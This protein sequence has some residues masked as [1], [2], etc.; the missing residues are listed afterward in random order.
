MKTMS[1]FLIYPSTL[2]IETISTSDNI[3]KKKGLSVKAT[4]AW[5]V[6]VI[7]TLFWLGDP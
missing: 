2:S 3:N 4:N 7:K 1:K 6:G 5:V